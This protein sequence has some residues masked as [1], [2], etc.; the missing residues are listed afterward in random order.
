MAISEEKTHLVKFLI[1]NLPLP[2]KSELKKIIDFSI[3]SKKSLILTTIYF[4]S[5]QKYFFKKKDVKNN[6][7]NLL[8]VNLNNK[9]IKN[10]K[11]L[12]QSQKIDYSLFVDL[13]YYTANVL[14][15]T[16]ITEF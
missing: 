13:L 12:Q 16:S 9:T 15:K 8:A 7:V 14:N 11:E 5:L 6:I 3:K 1:N 2:D 10:L 4:E